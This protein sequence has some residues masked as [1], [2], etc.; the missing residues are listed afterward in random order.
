MK[1]IGGKKMGQMSG[2]PGA[3][4]VCPVAIAVASSGHTHTPIW[5]EI[6]LAFLAI[7]GFAAYVL[8][9]FAGEE[10]RHRQK[11]VFLAF[12]FCSIV[13][14]VLAGLFVHWHIEFGW[15]KLPAF[16]A[17]YGF[18]ACVFLIYFA[19]GLRFWLPKEEDYYERRGRRG[20]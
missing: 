12:Y 6:L 13:V 17:I 7:F 15:Q 16:Y 10:P 9:C 8:L 1:A 3:F 18:S 19:K 4:F 20:E 5:Q 14:M 11:K 2:L